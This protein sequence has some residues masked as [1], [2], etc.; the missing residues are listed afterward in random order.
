MSTYT[1]LHNRV[2]ENLTVDYHTRIT[3]QKISALNEENLFVG[4]FSG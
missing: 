2:K 1:D 4:K 3:T